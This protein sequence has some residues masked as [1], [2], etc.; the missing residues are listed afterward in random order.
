LAERPYEC[1]FVLDSS[2]Y[3]TDP[4]GAENAVRE[5]LDRCGAKIVA[6]APWQEGKLAY[7]V[8]GHR[9]GLHYLAYI[10]MDG[11]QVGE[12]ARLCKLSDVVLRHMII[13]HSKHGPL[14]DEK[15]VP[16]LA[17]HHAGHA[18]EPEPVAVITT[19][20]TADTTT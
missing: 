1:M 10:R 8:D 13:D 11:S 19:N 15:L 14:F 17:Q 18:T 2:R 3:A 20:A 4:S 12:L 9:K 16:A 7:S 6:A 5:I